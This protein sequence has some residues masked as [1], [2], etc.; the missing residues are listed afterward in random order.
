MVQVLGTGALEE[1]AL[2]LVT[3]GREA[4][5]QEEDSRR[6]VFQNKAKTRRRQKQG[7]QRNLKVRI[8]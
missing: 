5:G 1:M 8:F 2:K 3:E 4:L 6:R 7:V